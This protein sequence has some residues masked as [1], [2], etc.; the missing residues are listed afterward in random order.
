LEAAILNLALNARESMPKGGVLT[1]EA[2]NVRVDAGDDEQNL[3]LA[4]GNYVDFAVSDSGTGMAHDIAAKVFDP[5]FSTKGPGASGLGLSM[6]QGFVKQSGGRT[7]IYSE[8]GIGTTVRMYL[9]QAEATARKSD[10]Y[11]FLSSPTASNAILSH[12][13]NERPT[14]R[15]LGSTER[16][17]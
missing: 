7:A 3:E 1:L 5:F 4:S 11:Q 16:Y 8:P 10:G 9:P 15:T 14:A 17:G 2:R 13:D 6:V 12:E